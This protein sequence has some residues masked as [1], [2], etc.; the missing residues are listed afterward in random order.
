MASFI[1][2]SRR[3]KAEGELQTYKDHLEELVKTRTGELNSAVDSLNAEVLEHQQTAEALL[4]SE[5]KF[6]EISQQFN[7]LLD[8]IPDSL[9]LM[10]PDLKVLW[11]N[12]GAIDLLARGRGRDNRTILSYLMA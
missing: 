10:S 9:I 2:I 5:K 8:A 7:I 3:K 12:R 4:S 6:R 1:D 11:A